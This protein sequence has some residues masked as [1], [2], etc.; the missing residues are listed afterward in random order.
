MTIY[1][2]FKLQLYNIAKQAQRKL[3]ITLFQIGIKL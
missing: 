1:E 3:P 2:V